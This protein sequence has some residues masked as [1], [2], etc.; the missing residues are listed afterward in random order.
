MPVFVYEGDKAAG[1]QYASLPRYFVYGGLVFTSLSLDYM[2]TMGRNW[3]ES[4]NGQLVYELFYRQHESPDKARPEP[5]VL[6]SILANP[7]NANFSVRGRA[8]VNKVNGVRIN[9]ME[10]LI[11]AFE[12]GDKAQHVIEFLP[13]NGIECIDREDAEQANAE[14]L[15]T[16]GVAQD[17]RL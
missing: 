12:K 3:F 10:D 8:L 11:A 9:K 5:I 14:I 2:K 1:N 15:K 17:R 13:N 16:Y 4:S 7:V 6:A